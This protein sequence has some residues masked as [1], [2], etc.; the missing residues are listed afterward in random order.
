MSPIAIPAAF[1]TLL[2]TATKT[3][4]PKNKTLEKENLCSIANSRMRIAKTKIK[5][6]L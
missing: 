6:K 2:P 4:K 3:N 1:E 5:E